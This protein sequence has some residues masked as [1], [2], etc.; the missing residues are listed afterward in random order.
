MRYRCTAQTSDSSQPGNMSIAR[1]NQN[2]VKDDS[3]QPF[4]YSGPPLARS[5]TATSSPKTYNSPL[6]ERGIDSN[7][8][9]HGMRSNQ[10]KLEAML[11]FGQMML[12]SKNYNGGHCSLAARKQL[13]F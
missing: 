6:I 10:E 5:Y 8:I 9:I 1:S 13:S 7:G 12:G 3:S 11:I 4:S 2:W